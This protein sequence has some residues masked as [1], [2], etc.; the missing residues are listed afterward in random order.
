MLKKEIHYLLLFLVNGFF[1]FFD[2]LLKFFARTNIIKTRIFANFFGW[3]YFENTGI[4]FSL[5]FSIPILII[6]TPII[7]LYLLYYLNKKTKKDLAAS[8]GVALIITGALSNFIDRLL[9]GFT[10]DYLKIFT[11]VINI[12]DVMI[13]VGI[14]LLVY[15]EIKNKEQKANSK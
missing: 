1:L 5:P 6:I 9:F 8:W 13:S 14:M 2:Q 11:A 15:N 3:E 7:I 10:V 4:A 12:A